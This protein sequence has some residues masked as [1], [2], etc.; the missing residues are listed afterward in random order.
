ML[1]LS[2]NENR[3]EKSFFVFSEVRFEKTQFFA[4]KL[5]FFEKSADVSK[6]LKNLS[7]FSAY[8]RNYIPS[9]NSMPSFIAISFVVQILTRGGSFYPPHVLNVP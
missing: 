4:K 8:F 7:M 2:K 1:G 3:S 6:I 5:H 9:A